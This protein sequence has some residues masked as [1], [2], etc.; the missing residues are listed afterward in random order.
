MKGFFLQLS[1][2]H[3]DEALILLRHLG[4]RSIQ[5]NNIKQ[6]ISLII[7]KNEALDNMNNMLFSILIVIRNW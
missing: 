1:V 7:I 5:F 2:M 3:T 4:M 6:S